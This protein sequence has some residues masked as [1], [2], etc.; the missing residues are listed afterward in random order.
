[1]H[2]IPNPLPFLG[3]HEILMVWVAAHAE[4][5]MWAFDHAL[6]WLLVWVLLRFFMRV[7]W[8]GK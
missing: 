5:F 8:D 6:F 3:P 2:T 4:E 1:M 7:A